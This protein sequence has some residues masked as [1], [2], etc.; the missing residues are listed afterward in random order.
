[1]TELKLKVGGWDDFIASATAA[2]KRL[3]KGDWTPQPATY[4][5]ET[6]AQLL[7]LLTAN[8]W[9]LLETL[10]P[11]GPV[12]VRALAKA[13]GRDYRGVHADTMA[14]IEAG[15]VE[16]DETMKI[17]VPWSRITADISFEL[18]AA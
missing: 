16:R 10:R 8:R 9:T 12:S 18:A 14:L 17:F 7:R 5:F 13:L 3:D 6:M 2:A 4:S 11:L 15:L 1:M